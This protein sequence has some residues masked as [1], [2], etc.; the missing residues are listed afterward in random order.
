MRPT[1]MSQREQPAEALALNVRLPDGT[2]QCFSAAFH[3]GRDP[4]CEVQIQDVH[5]SRRHARVSLVSGQWTIVDLQSRN[6][7]LID[8]DQVESAPIGDGIRVTLGE[9]GPSLELGPRL[10]ST[11]PA[12]SDAEPVRG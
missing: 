8:G 12:P 9:D 2:V 11:A 6:G 10:R 5:V 3:I 7:L 1:H 4:D